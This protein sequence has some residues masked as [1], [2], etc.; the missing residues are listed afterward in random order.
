MPLSE[1][2]VLSQFKPLLKMD[3]LAALGLAK[4]LEQ[5]VYVRELAIETES[6][7]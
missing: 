7:S 5:Q 4:L 2:N 6:A 3:C 1:T